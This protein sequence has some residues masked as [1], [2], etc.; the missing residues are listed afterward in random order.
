MKNILNI[1]KV[2][3]ALAIFSGIVIV[4]AQEIEK[5]DQTFLYEIGLATSNT[6][7]SLGY[8]HFNNYAVLTNQNVKEGLSQVSLKL[9]YRFKL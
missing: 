7:I 6:D 4:D 2:F 1:K 9:A 5:Q 8:E 3:T